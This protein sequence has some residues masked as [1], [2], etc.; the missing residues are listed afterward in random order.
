[1]WS[2]TF[3]QHFVVPLPGAELLRERRLRHTSAYI[4][5]ASFLSR[6]AISSPHR[7]G[8]SSGNYM[9]APRGFDGFALLTILIPGTGAA[10][11]CSDCSTIHDKRA[12]GCA[13]AT[14]Y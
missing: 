14:A 11:S 10:L 13:D 5:D 2:C 8:R 12:S 4:C 6:S 7:L 9:P 1:N 3:R